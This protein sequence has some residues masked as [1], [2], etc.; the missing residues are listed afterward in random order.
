M[1]IFDRN[2]V[3]EHWVSN[4][5]LVKCVLT[6]SVLCCV[7]VSVLV[8]IDRCVEKP[9]RNTH[10][11]THW[12]YTLDQ[13]PWTF[14][15]G[16]TCR[17]LFTDLRHLKHS[18]PEQLCMFVLFLIQ[19]LGFDRKNSNLFIDLLMSPVDPDRSLLTTSE[20]SE[21]VTEIVFSHL[22]KHKK[23]LI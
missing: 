5:M 16:W 23:W 18:L 12:G 8:K 7:Q 1:Y 13:R 10:I 11:N 15:D 3:V 19:M 9:D 20:N 4:N 6:C 14:L 22:T 17:E 2:L 21:P